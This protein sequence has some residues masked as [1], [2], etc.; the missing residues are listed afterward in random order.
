[1]Q[2]LHLQ[3]PG[4]YFGESIFLAPSLI[5]NERHASAKLR[6]KKKKRRFSFT[7]RQSW[8][9]HLLNMKM[10][11]SRKRCVDTTDYSPAGY[12]HDMKCIQCYTYPNRR[13]KKNP[14]NST[15]VITVVQIRMPDEVRREKER[16]Q[17]SKWKK[18]MRYFWCWRAN[19]PALADSKSQEHSGN[20]HIASLAA[21]PLTS[22]GHS[23]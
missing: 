9:P 6:N 23:N 14:N 2:W 15:S 5:W 11:F 4:I 8:I 16:L 18:M 12:S 17:S 13:K 20:F 1:M 21:A 22:S 10:R 7:V 19:L 3:R